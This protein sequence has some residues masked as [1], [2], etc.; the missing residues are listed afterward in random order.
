VREPTLQ[1]SEKQAKAQG[2]RKQP[3]AAFAWKEL[4]SGSR[5]ADAKKDRIKI[6]VKGQSR[7]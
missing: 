6:K 3:K 1:I 7:K 2:E 5:K 4:T